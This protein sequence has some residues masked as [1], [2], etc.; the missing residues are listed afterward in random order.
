MLIVVVD[1]NR[2]MYYLKGHFSPC[3]IIHL[4]LVA[5]SF[6]TKVPN[7]PRGYSYLN[8]AVFRFLLQLIGSYKVRMLSRLL[9]RVNIKKNLTKERNLDILIL[10]LD[11]FTSRSYECLVVFVNDEGKYLKIYC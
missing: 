6:K 2:C 3:C 4:N 8:G 9:P 10:A 11:L 1:V 5:R 7:E